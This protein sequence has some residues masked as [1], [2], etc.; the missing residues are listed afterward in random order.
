LKKGERKGVGQNDRR[1]MS[2]GRGLEP[3]TQKNGNKEGDPQA[4]EEPGGLHYQSTQNLGAQEQG[5]LTE[6]KK[7]VLRV[8]RKREMSGPEGNETKENR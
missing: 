5:P 8:G 1:D 6:R 4:T 3:R 7:K 2:P